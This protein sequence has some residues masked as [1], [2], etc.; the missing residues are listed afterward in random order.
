MD[1]YSTG[2]TKLPGQLGYRTDPLE[3]IFLGLLEAAFLA[4]RILSEFV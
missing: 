1:A 2:E 4:G 3:V